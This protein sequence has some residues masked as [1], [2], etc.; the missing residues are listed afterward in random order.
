MFCNLQCKVL[1]FYVKIVPIKYFI[2][3]DRIVSGVVLILFFHCSLLI[4]RSVIDF[5]AL[6]LYPV[7]LLN[8][9]I[10]LAFVCMYIS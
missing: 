3:F 2:L 6:I 10:S 4:N 5:C 8:S 1:Y 7:T 9:F